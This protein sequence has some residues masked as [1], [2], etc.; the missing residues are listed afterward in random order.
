MGRAWLSEGLSIPCGAVSLGSAVVLT[1]AAVLGLTVAFALATSVGAPAVVVA[2]GRGGLPGS[3]R[4]GLHAI[5]ADRADTVAT[6]A[7]ASRSE[8]MA[9]YRS[10][11]V[12]KRSF[13]F[14]TT[15]ILH[16]RVR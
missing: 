12:H 6:K 7:G 16:S 13:V 9:Q 11:T 15:N 8:A 4:G 14:A 1:L 10:S 2:V 3:G 5:P